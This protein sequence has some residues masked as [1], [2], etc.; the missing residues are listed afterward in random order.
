MSQVSGIYKLPPEVRRELKRRIRRAGYGSFQQ[1]AEWLT[2]QGFETS[3]SAIHRF[4]KA[5][6]QS[7]ERHGVDAELALQRGADLVDLWDQLNDLRDKEQ[8][9]LEQIRA[10]M[11]P[12]SGISTKNEM[13]ESASKSASIPD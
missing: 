8:A 11:K 4:G 7:D 1:H 3:K 10:L 2:D 5:L 12:A 13:L 6:K 9:L